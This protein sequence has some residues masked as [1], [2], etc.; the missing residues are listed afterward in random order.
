MCLGEA[1][2]VMELLLVDLQEGWLVVM[3]AMK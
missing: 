1:V 3:E 2:V